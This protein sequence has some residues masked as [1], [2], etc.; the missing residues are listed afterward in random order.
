MPSSSPPST[1]SP[2]ERSP[3]EARQDEVRAAIEGT[4]KAG[5]GDRVFRGVA[6]IAGSTVLAILALIAISTGIQSWPAFQEQG[7]GFVLTNDW[8]PAAGHFGALAFIYGTILISIVAL[9][10]A[11]P[12][13][14][15]IALFTTEMAPRRVKT[16]ISFV[17]DLLAAI[18]SVV[19]GLWGLAVLIPNLEPIYKW[20]ADTFGTIGAGDSSLFWVVVGA[21]FRWFFAPPSNG[22]SFMTAGLILAFMIT[23]II[24]SLSR[25]VIS[26]VPG[27]Q[28]EAALALGATRWE[29]IRSAIFPWSRGGI[30]GAVMLG[31]GRAMGETIAAALVIGS[32]PQITTRL[33]ANGDAMAATIAN[34]FNEASGLF[35][36]ALVG[37]GLV[38]FV[39]TIIVNMSAQRIISHF[40][41]KANQA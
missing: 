40:D 34:Q 22:T 4:R 23:P 19:F 32:N 35:R 37:L 39:L 15:G 31:L 36:S 7:F 1:L 17:V 26:T 41:N 9:V 33:F 20:I 21:P 18:P 14:I 30:T 16:V 13:S 6:L 27:H 29:M 5:R 25:E 38:L 28:R 2:P 10:L 8:N 12:A 3:L 24:T 11:V